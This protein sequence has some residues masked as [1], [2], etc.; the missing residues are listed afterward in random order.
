V[1]HDRGHVLLASSISLIAS[2]RVVYSNSASVISAG[3]AFAGERTLVT[4]MSLKPL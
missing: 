2:L 4:L 3:M 1:G